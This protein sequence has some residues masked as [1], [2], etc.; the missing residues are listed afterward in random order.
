MWGE[1]WRGGKA[2]TCFCHYRERENCGGVLQDAAAV[3]DWG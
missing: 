1:L 2:R 3:D